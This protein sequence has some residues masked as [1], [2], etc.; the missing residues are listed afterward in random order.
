MPLEGMK[1]SF[2]KQAI[3]TVVNVG[4]RVVMDCKVINKGSWSSCVWYKDKRV[5]LKFLIDSGV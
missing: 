2:E 1:Q 4:H 5:S 3:E